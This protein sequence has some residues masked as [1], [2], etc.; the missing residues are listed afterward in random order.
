MNSNE[1]PYT[2]EKDPAREMLY[3]ER[4]SLTERVEASVRA[5]PVGVI[6]GAVVI[7]VA[8]AA[9]VRLLTGDAPRTRSARAAERAAE[10][11]RD[12]SEQLRG[13]VEPYADRARAGMVRS[14]EAIRGAVDD[15]PDIKSLGCHLREWWNGR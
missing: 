13:Y 7:G 4:P 3:P 8:T 6:V 15:L 5:N 1:I 10:F 14:S 9:I 2:S 12:A 11:L